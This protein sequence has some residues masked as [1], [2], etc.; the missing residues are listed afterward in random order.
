M[1]KKQNGGTGET[2]YFSKQ[3][4]KSFGSVVEFR[5]L[6]NDSDRGEDAGEDSGYLLGSS[7]RQLFAWIL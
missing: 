5:S 2:I 6:P 1:S 3:A 7:S 4:S